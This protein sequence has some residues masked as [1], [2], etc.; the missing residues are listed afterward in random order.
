MSLKNDVFVKIS[1]TIINPYIKDSNKRIIGYYCTYIPEELLHAADLIPF[2]IR[3][4]GNEDTDLGDVYMVRFTCSF[5]RMTLDLALKGGYD[6]LNGLILVNCCDHARRMY[7]VFDLK[8]FSRK[9]FKKKPPRFYTPLPH[10]ITKEGFEYYKNEIIKLKKEIEEKYQLEEI[11]D[12]TLTKSIEI[13]N[14]NRNLLKEIYDLRILDAPKL[15]GSDAIQLSMANTSVP[16][17]IANQELER[18]LNSLK[19]IEGIKTESKRIML[20]GSVIDNT[21]FV[22]VIENSG[23]LVVADFLC[24]GTRNFLDNVEIKSNGNPLEEIV[25]RVYYRMSCPRMMDDHIRRLEYVKKEI[26][27]AKIDGVILQRINNCDLHGCENMMLEHELRDL[28]IPVFNMDRESFQK[29]YTRIQ[30]RIEA[31]LEMIK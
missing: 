21:G 7:E 19:E 31:F 26:K 5:V 16:K 18:I 22:D 24:F 28:E 17:E 27:R 30:T 20:I 13:Y 15:T 2:R 1:N 29:D 23:A 14:K 3:A 4:T 10:I 6:F 12:E 8:V 9:Q 11:S 25:K